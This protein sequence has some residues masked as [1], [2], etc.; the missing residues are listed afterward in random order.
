MA[1]LCVVAALWLCTGELPRVRDKLYDKALGTILCVISARPG[2]ALD[3]DLTALLQPASRTFCGLAPHDDR[4]EVGFPDALSVRNS[5]LYGE[6][7]LTDGLAA[8][9]RS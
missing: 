4:E 1:V 9:S 8:G 7:E 3:H 5:A 6:A 2:F